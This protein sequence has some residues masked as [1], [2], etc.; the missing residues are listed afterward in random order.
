M[1]IS[2]AD[3]DI[4]RHTDLPLQADQGLLVNKSEGE[5]VQFDAVTDSGHRYTILIT[6]DDLRAI[7]EAFGDVV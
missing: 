5:V 7:R 3:R 2:V 4:V 6:R 1:R